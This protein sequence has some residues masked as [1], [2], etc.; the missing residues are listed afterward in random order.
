MSHFKSCFLY[1]ILLSGCSGGS[2]DADSDSPKAKVVVNAGANKTVDENT[3][4]ILTAQAQGQSAELSYQWRVTPSLS[5]THDNKNAAEASFVAPTTTS[6]LNYVF[7]LEVSD[8]LGNKGSDT[9]EYQIVPVNLAPVTV[10]QA[11]QF[12]GLAENHFPA[13]VQITLDGSASYDPDD[14]DTTGA[15]AT[16]K[17]QQTAGAAVLEGISTDGAS[18]VFK[19]PVLDTDNSLAFSLTVTDAEGAQSTQT[20]N[21]TV[22]SASNTLPQANAGLDHQLTSGEIII[23]AGKASTSV[24]A[25]EPL[26]YR[27]LN[28]S[29]LNPVIEQPQQLL[30][31]AVAP[32]VS[33]PQVITFT[34]EVTDVSGNKVEDFVN[35]EIRPQLVRPINDTGIILQATDQLL[36][37]EQQL[38]FPGQDGQRGRDIIAANDLAD[39]AGRGE[40]GFDFTRLNALGDEVD[41]N[42]TAW[43]CVRDNVSGLVWEVKSPVGS[44]DLHSSSHTYSWYLAE[45]EDDPSG[46]QNNVLASCSLNE[47]NTSAYVDAVNQQGLC[48]FNDWRL[49]THQELL[50]LVHFGHDAAPM[51]DAEYFPHTTAGLGSPVWYWTN[52]SSADGAAGEISNTAWAVDFTSGNDN[53]LSKATPVRIRLVR[54]GR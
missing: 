4:V 22:Q 53:F 49:P 45:N 43:S 31:Y 3:T 1:I 30:T 28:D 14:D 21:L 15:I 35:I 17:W 41:A 34:L 38:A 6:I 32:K 51:I 9:V 52:Q 47:C 36:S 26:Q 27:W 24:P 44:G 16:Y 13:G 25:A 19:S 7:T 11:N 50:S 37:A 54:A 12:S 23:L 18:L 39:K 46:L 10:I 42:S 48:N 8:A 33:S 5:I 40:Q 29:L 20:I 2:L